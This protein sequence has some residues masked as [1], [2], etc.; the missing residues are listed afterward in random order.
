L[1]ERFGKIIFLSMVHRI[2]TIRSPYFLIIYRIWFIRRVYRNDLF[3]TCIT[4]SFVKF[5]F[6]A[7]CQSLLLTTIRTEYWIRNLKKF[8]SNHRR[9]FI[10]KFPILIG[11]RKQSSTLFT[12]LCFF[13]IFLHNI[14]NVVKY[15]TSKQ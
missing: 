10:I 7:K 12:C 9:N 3:P 11:N 13:A 14:Y 5:S 1:E 15:F 8:S 4:R 6:I 2:P